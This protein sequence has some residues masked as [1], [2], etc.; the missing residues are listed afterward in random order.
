MR[1]G[2]SRPSCW[3]PEFLSSRISPCREIEMTTHDIPNCKSVANKLP[4]NYGDAVEKFRHAKLA[5]HFPGDVAPSAPAVIESAVRRVQ[6]EGH[7]DD[8]VADYAII[9]DIPVP[10]LAERKAGLA[11]TIRNAETAALAND[12]GDQIAKTI[13]AEA[14]A[15]SAELGQFSNGAPD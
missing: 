10:T 6:T 4:Y 8:F 9:D 1:I 5:H 2:E 11:M 13:S 3:P 12:Q 7:A 15:L 14:D